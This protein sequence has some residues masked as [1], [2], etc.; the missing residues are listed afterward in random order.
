[1]KWEKEERDKFE[2]E[3]GFAPNKDISGTTSLTEDK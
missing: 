1:M 3:E 2:E